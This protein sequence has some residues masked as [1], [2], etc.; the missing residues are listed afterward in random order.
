MVLEGHPL[1]TSGASVLARGVTA[2]DCRSGLLQE[3]W[4]CLGPQPTWAP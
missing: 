2:S 4:Q 1:P 3:S